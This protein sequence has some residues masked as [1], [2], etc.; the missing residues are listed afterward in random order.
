MSAI[1]RSLGALV[2]VLMFAVSAAPARAAP[3]A[4]GPATCRIG[5]YFTSVHNIDTAA[6]TF[7]A[8]FWM[9]SVCSTADIKP[10]ETVQFLNA[11]AV[12]GQLDASLPRGRNWWSTRMFR[13][14]FRQDFHMASYPF[15]DQDL[16]LQIEESVLDT[17]GLRYAL[18]TAESGVDESL[19]T[20]GW[21]ISDLSLKAGETTRATTFGDPSLPGGK[22]SYASARITL[23]ADR[24][25]KA[26]NFIKATF[27]LF[28]AAFLALISMA[29]DVVETETFMGRMGA[30]GSILFAVV[31]SYVSLDQLVGPHQGLYFL[32]QMHFAALLL[33]LLATA[34]SVPAHRVAGRWADEDTVRRWDV[35][36]TLALL[37]LYVIA[38]AVMIFQALRGA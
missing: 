6:G 25:A 14:T 31:L 2:A 27:P 32:D 38:N 28:I 35:R 37:G 18:D 30:L 11:E 4:P 16:V 24:A 23:R 34:W 5:V 26:T 17:R 21:V 22:S 36:V 13:G 3:A 8:D 20:P 12:E 29:F 9:W 7:D 10:L 33:L 19:I 1:I 15:D